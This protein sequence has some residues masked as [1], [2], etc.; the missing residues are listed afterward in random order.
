M[1]FMILPE[2]SLRSMLEGYGIVEDSLS[3]VRRIMPLG[4]AAWRE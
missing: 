4:C 2:H 3:S 1:I